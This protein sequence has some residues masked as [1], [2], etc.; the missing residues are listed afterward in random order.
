MKIIHCANFSEQRNGSVYYAIDRKLSNGLIRN[1]HFV[2]DFSYRDL[3][4][5]STFFKSK[6]FGRKKVNQKLIESIDN[7]LP[8]VVLLGHSELIEDE[9]LAQIKSKYPQI[10]IAMWWVDPFDKID[11][12][13]TRLS[14]LDAFFATT[15]TS[16]LQEIFPKFKSK[17]FFFPNPCDS[18]V[19]I[20]KSFENKEYS[21]DVLYVGRSDDRRKEFIDRL[22]GLSDI[23]VGIFGDKKDNLIFGHGYFDLIASSKV[24]L[25]FSRYNDI[26]KY[27]S[28]RIVQL[29][30]SGVLTMSPRIPNYETLFSDDE[31]VYFDDFDDFEK[32]LRFYLQNDDKR[33]EI[34]QSGYI[35]AHESFNSTKV[36]KYMLKSIFEPKEINDI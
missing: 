35:K 34:A 32:K 36:S 33:R 4:R 3:A 17:L 12:I 25:N 2:Y 19:E 5:C 6:K 24:A 9:T 21:Y 15:G 28:D 30:A 11:H 1:G 20:H 14:Y 16:K 27:S 29:T 10:K 7:I 8:D 26:D 23:K 13:H 22:R 18:S 31:I